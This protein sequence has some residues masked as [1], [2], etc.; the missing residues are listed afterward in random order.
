MPAMNS[1]TF[2]MTRSYLPTA[3]LQSWLCVA[4]FLQTLLYCVPSVVPSLTFYA[5]AAAERSLLEFLVP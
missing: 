5:E 4:L 3:A 1:N 2:R